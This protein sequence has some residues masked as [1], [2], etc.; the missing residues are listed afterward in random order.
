MNTHAKGG[1]LLGGSK[2]SRHS[3]RRAGLALGYQTTGAGPSVLLLP[4][5]GCSGSS[6][7]PWLR[8][9]GPLPFRALL[10]D[11]RGTGTS[12]VSR[13]PYDMSAMADDAAAVVRRES[14]TRAVV[15]VG[16]SMGGM[17]AQHL[18]LRHPDLVSGL[19]LVSTSP[20]AP[21]L[22]SHSLWSMLISAT[23]LLSRNPDTWS[24][25]DHTLVH[26]DKSREQSRQLLE[27]LRQIQR[28]EPYSRIN[29]W[30]QLRAIA[31]HETTDRLDTVQVPVEVI[32]GAGDGVVSPD[33]SRLL[34]QR[35][36]RAELT[37]LEDAGH[38]IPCEAP[39]VVLRAILRLLDRAV[40]S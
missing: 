10:M 25:G 18:A 22:E 24:L 4:G 17:I 2:F 1:G 6:W 34:A 3:V 20:R 8:S 28:T 30:L 31:K 40:G 27:P 7:I 39:H 32:A 29:A 15:V 26:P 33:N 38:D 5:F 13:F 37:L 9:I 16:Q 14:D 35:L 11:N 21:K 36:P 19:V 23:G 12:A